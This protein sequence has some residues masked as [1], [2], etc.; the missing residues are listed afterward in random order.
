MDAKEIFPT[1]GH[2]LSLVHLLGLL[3]QQLVTRLTEAHDGGTLDGS[4]LDDGE[5]LLGD[6]CSILVLGDGIGV[7]ERVVCVAE[8]VCRKSRINE[9]EASQRI[10]PCGTEEQEL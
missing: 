5:N 9:N 6:C 7:C 8:S 1:L 10:P 3:F 2:L 4:S